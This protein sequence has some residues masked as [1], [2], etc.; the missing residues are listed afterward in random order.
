[1]AGNDLH[2]IFTPSAGCDISLAIALSFSP[3]S[4][5]TGFISEWRFDFGP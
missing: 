1:M 4:F 3:G 5:G 2:Q